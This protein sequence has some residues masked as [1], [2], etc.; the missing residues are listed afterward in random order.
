MLIF[1]EMEKPSP[2]TYL[3]VYFLVHSASLTYFSF[4]GCC[5]T[6]AGER[7]REML[8][9]CFPHHGCWGSERIELKY[10]VNSFHLSADWSLY[11]FLSLCSFHMIML[12]RSPFGSPPSVSLHHLLLSL[13]FSLHM[14]TEYFYMH[15]MLTN[16]KQL[17]WNMCSHNVGLCYNHTFK[18]IGHP[19]QK[20]LSASVSF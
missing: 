17:G 16:D 20:N 4:G 3:I 19:K 10:A 18:E 1:V 14:Q 8:Y 9:C 7:E 12:S 2:I 13:S 5:M 15:F 6:P 11:Q